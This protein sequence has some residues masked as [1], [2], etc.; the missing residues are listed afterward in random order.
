MYHVRTLVAIPGSDV[1]HLSLHRLK[2][3][4]HEMGFNEVSYE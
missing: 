3:P 2:N 1:I 4:F